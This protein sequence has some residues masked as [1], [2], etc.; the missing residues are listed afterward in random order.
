MNTPPN[1]SL[2]VNDWVASLRGERNR[3]NPERPHAW[4]VE[5]ECSGNGAIVPVATLFLTNRECLWRCVMC[6]LW[7]NTLTETVPI[8]AIPR[9]IDYGLAQLIHPFARN[10]HP[11]PPQQI[12]LYNSGSFFDPQA[13]PLEDYD[14]IA[15]R[16][17]GFARVIVESHPA[18]IGEKCLAF[19]RAL[20]R[21]NPDG[22]LEIAVGLETVHP[23]ILP[24]LNKHATLDLFKQRAAF[25]GAHDIAL[26]AFVLVQPPFMESGEV[27]DWTLRAVHF[28]FDCGATAVSLIPT[29][30]GNGALEH[31]ASA[32]HFS[33][34]TLKTLETVLAAG[35]ALERGRVFGDLWDADEFSECDAC[36]EPRINRL[37]EMNLRQMVLSEVA[38]DTCA[39]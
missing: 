21:H 22:R 24:K 19:Q 35:I 9:Q 14:A 23:D 2:P 7:K 12:K 39:A 32:G 31:L 15:E 27:L 29:R 26:R 8:G 3:V 34:P 5:D 6:D 1:A 18:L 10:S 36:F 11:T 16:V 38:C 33:P 4:T 20:R 17:A 37:R 30:G 13:I 25:L 28:A